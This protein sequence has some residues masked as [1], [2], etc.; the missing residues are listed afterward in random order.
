MVEDLGMSTARNLANARTGL[1]D[2][3]TLL[4]IIAC[5]AITLG[6]YLRLAGINSKSLWLDEVMTV[7]D[8][9]MPTLAAMFSHFKN[10]PL[11]PLYY[12]S[13]WT[14]VGFWGLNDVS[15]RSLSTVS[16]LLAL[17]VMY[18]TWR[19]LLG[20]RAMAWAMALLALNSYHIAYSQDAKMYSMVWLLAIASSGCFLNAVSGRP[21]RAGWLIGYGISTACLP[22]VSYVGIV[23]LLVQGIYGA[24]LLV[25]SPR[26]RWLV[27]D[28]AVTASI[29]FVPTTLYSP[30]AVSAASGRYSITWIP[31]V[32]WA[33]VP[34][35]LYRFVGAL[36]LGY[37][38][39]GEKPAGWGLPLAG[40][41]GPCVAVATV[42]LA[43][44]L[45]RCLGRLRAEL[46]ADP[47]GAE[48]TSAPG[49]VD[50]TPAG[51]IAYLALWFLAPVV[52]AL[53]FSLTVYSLWGVPRYLFAVAP[54]LLIW[55]SAALGDMR[56]ERLALGLGMGLLAVNLTVVA[57]GQVH[58]TRVP[59]RE[60]A[61]TIEDLAATFAC[62]E[63]ST[64]AK[65]GGDPGASTDMAICSIGSHDFTR[66]C[67]AYALSHDPT[68]PAVVRP[69]FIDLE[70]A[71]ARRRPFVVIMIVYMGPT[72]PD[73][74]RGELEAK[75][76]G[77]TC[78]QLYWQT[79]YEEPYTSMPTPFMR[80]SVEVWLCTQGPQPSSGRV[81]PSARL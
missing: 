65:R 79:V 67:I 66:G 71:L 54:A 40:V 45:A 72:T 38:P 36:L 55:L 29:A 47:E 73:G 35:E 51:V 61:R 10:L 17:P 76:P 49:R 20:P 23:P 52:G 24:A 13:L 14:W 5:A 34:A 75:T 32:T 26:R 9:N 22:M 56:R 30:I 31:E 53:V 70:T 25:L 8:V 57:F 3:W 48:P 81:K 19:P 50:A 80:H 63:V 41:Y 6:V 33:R 68:T 64:G 46:S 7:D 78:R 15:I 77:F 4:K 62:L 39:S 58:Y 1:K 18:L 27:M 16:G 2:H 43:S 28:A 44:T 12:I 59:W 60:M 37:R 69:E 11:P 74:M 42:V 21:R